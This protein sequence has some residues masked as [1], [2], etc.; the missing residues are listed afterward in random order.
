MREV[1]SR[2]VLSASLAEISE[3]PE[4]WASALLSGSAEEKAEGQGLL[5]VLL[6]SPARSGVQYVESA[7][8]VSFFLPASRFTAWLPSTEA[9]SRLLNASGLP[10]ISLSMKLRRPTTPP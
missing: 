2:A 7:P 9:L 1:L 6:G 4:P 3:T 8:T 5:C 10:P